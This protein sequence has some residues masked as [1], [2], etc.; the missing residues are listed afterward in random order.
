MV[1]SQN[2]ENSIILIRAF[3]RQN[4]FHRILFVLSESR[5]HDIKFYF[6]NFML[7]WRIQH[8]LPSFQQFYMSSRVIL[9]FAQG[10]F[11][12]LECPE[13]NILNKFFL[14]MKGTVAVTH[15]RTMDTFK[16]NLSAKIITCIVYVELNLFCFHMINK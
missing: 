16:W 13:V 7:L 14:Y 4:N 8:S 15:L 3:C 1:F 11:F 2:G 10:D 9:I 12:R 5:A 6:P